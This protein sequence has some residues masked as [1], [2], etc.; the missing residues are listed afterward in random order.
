LSC[1][2]GR[3]DLTSEER[4]VRIWSGAL[5]P[6]PLCLMRK[7]GCAF[8]NVG[9]LVEAGQKLDG[10]VNGMA[11]L[12]KADPRKACRHQQARPQA[13]GLPQG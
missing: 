13:A 5:L 6:E 2:A 10:L 8:A 11:L 4:T 12:A 7:A 3:Y 9:K 1:G